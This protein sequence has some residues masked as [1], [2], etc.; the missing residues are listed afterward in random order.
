MIQYVLRVCDSL[1]L[2]LCTSVCVYVCMCV[3]V[4][5]CM[6]VCVRMC[7]CVCPIDI[8]GEIKL[9]WLRSFHDN[10]QKPLFPDLTIQIKK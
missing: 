3:Y 7:V 2:C 8:L 6:C 4:C 9:S 1:C 10:C 5:V